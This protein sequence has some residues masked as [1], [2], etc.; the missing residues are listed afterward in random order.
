MFL[1]SFAKFLKSTSNFE[2]FEKTKMTII[3]YYF[4]N[5]RRRKMWLEYCLKTPVSENHSTVN[6]LKGPKHYLNLID[7]TF[8]IFFFILI[9]TELQKCLS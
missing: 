9:E 4:R 3:A 6:T 1:T 8:I 7:S 5:Y 2:D